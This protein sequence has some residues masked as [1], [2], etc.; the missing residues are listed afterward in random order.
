MLY[1]QVR[2]ELLCCFNPW[3]VIIEI[4]QFFPVIVSNFVPLLTVLLILHAIVSI[5][6]Q[7][8]QVVVGSF[9]MVVTLIVLEH[10]N[11]Q[12]S[13]GDHIM[14]R[15]VALDRVQTA[16]YVSFLMPKA[17]RKEMFVIKSK[18]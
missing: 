1:I 13:A 17:N 3:L 4:K 14:Q 8:I 6:V 16:L 9:L 18:S 5:E 2:K 15:I 10:M 7:V 11:T 12:V